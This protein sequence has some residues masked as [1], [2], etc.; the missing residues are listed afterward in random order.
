ME[1]SYNIVPEGIYKPQTIFGK[2]CP[3][4]DDV[5]RIAVIMDRVFW[6]EYHPEPLVVWRMRRLENGK[7]VDSGSSSAYGG[8]VVNDI[9]FELNTTQWLM[10]L[11]PGKGRQIKLDIE[12]RRHTTLCVD[13]DM[14]VR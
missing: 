11:P 8:R 2:V 12:I 4:D 14:T 10:G 6:E 9:G 7:W 13:L 5:N 3:A 1:R